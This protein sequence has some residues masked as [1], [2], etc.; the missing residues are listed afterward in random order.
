MEGE[1]Q[2]PESLKAFLPFAKENCII[3]DD[4]RHEHL[5]QMSEAE[6]QA[7]LAKIEPYADDLSEFMTVSESDGRHSEVYMCL[8]AMWATRWAIKMKLSLEFVINPSD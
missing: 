1:E 8:L 5:V 4:K 6:R 3:D 7:L 2:V